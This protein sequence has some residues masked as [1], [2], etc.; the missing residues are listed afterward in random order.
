M[1]LI[2]DADA[3]FMEPTDLWEN[4]LEGKYKERALRF[5]KD[6]ATGMETMAIE[7]GK[8]H[9]LLP[10]ELFKLAVGFGQSPERIADPTFTFHDGPLLV[11]SG[12]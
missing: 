8:K 4:Y 1:S 10:P 11:I 9:S 12:A 6:E 5:V 3:H 7:G 2:I